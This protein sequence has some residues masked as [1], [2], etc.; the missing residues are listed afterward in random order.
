MP[1][2]R[3]DCYGALHIR[4]GNLLD[5]CLHHPLDARGRFAIS[6]ASFCYIFSFYYLPHRTTRL[7]VRPFWRSWFNNV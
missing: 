4:A 5:I 3:R 2:Y 7:R 1:L 6:C